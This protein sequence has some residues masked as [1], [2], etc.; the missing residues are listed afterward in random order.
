M[1]FLNNAF[2]TIL[3]AVASLL[4]FILL[5]FAFIDMFKHL[6]LVKKSNPI[7][8]DGL[9]DYLYAIADKCLIP[10]VFEEAIF[11]LLLFCGMRFLLKTFVF[12]KE[13]ALGNNISIITSATLFALA[14]GS[15]GM[16]VHQFLMGAIY[17]F[18]VLKTGNILYSVL[19]HFINNFL[20]ITYTF[21]MHTDQIDYSWNF[22]TVIIGIMLA[23]MGTI[24]IMQYIKNLKKEKHFG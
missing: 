16:F 24:V 20:I 12:K 7:V 23:I 1:K 6:D 15:F 17:A 9:S 5:D 13:T 14:H 4:A 21:V 8:V 19:A 11:R 18:I 2:Y 10:A 3:I 22:K